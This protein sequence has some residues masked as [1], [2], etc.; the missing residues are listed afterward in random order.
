MDSSPFLIL[1]GLGI[2]Y[3]KED[4]QHA[5]AHIIQESTKCFLHI[6]TN[7]IDRRALREAYNALFIIWNGIITESVKSESYLPL[8]QIWNS[9]EEL[10]TYYADNSIRLIRTETLEDFC[11]DYI[12]IL[13]KYNQDDILTNSVFHIENIFQKCLNKGLPDENLIKDLDYM[14]NLD[15][16][17]EHNVDIEI[18]WHYIAQNIPGLLEKIIDKSIQAKKERIF[19]FSTSSFSNFI[20]VVRNE[21]IGKYQESYI[22]GNIVSTIF[23]DFGRAAENNMINSFRASGEIGSFTMTDI[24]R[25][26]PPYLKRTISSVV[27]YVKDLQLKGKLSVRF[28]DTL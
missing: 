26:N 3:I 16:N 14:F 21:K 24:I 22:V 25:A 6:I 28:A 10:Y 19:D 2:K 27:E 18:Q 11:R 20:S 5:A 12:D 8:K 7:D 17:I 13:F 1:R 9:I 4:N 15:R 23:Y